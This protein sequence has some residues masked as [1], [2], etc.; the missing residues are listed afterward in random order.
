MKKYSYPWLISVT[1]V[2]LLVIFFS[3]TWRVEID[4]VTF[5]YPA[6][7][8][9]M[10]YVA[11]GLALLGS[12]LFIWFII[13]KGDTRNTSPRQWLTVAG[14]SVLLAFGLA[15]LIQHVILTTLTWLLPGEESTYTVPYQYTSGGSRSCS[16]AYVEDPQL[17]KEIRICYPF[18][19]Y[20]DDNRITVIKRSNALGIVILYAQTSTLDE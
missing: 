16:G 14:G 19:Y 15:M 6:M 1:V 11:L 12:A 8:R 5:L 9:D 20:P 2:T 18:G 10:L 4:R 3:V 13:R 7:I 17:Q